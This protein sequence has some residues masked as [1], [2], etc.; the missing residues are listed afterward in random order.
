MKDLKNTQKSYDDPPEV[1][2]ILKNTQNSNDDPPEDLRSPISS[3]LV[4]TPDSLP[5]DLSQED[6]F[7]F[8][9][10]LLRFNAKK[11]LSNLST[12][13]QSPEK[14]FSFLSTLHDK[15]EEQNN[16]AIKPNSQ[17]NII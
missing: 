2:K 10:D 4:K 15:Y 9:G 16:K 3:L 7:E 6:V 13:I 1:L 17:S 14:F 12:Y 5:P 11:S 8:I